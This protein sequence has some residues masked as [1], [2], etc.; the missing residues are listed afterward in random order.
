GVKDA[1]ENGSLFWEAVQRY[2]KVFPPEYSNIIRAGETSSQLPET[3]LDL[4]E[5]VEWIDQIMA[6]VRQA[7]LY[8]AV[9]TVVVGAFVLLLFT[10]VI[11]KFSLLFESIN[12]E[13]PLITRVLFAI[14]DGV[15]STWWLWT[16]VLMFLSVGIK[17]G[18][19]YFDKFDRLMDQLK[20]KVPIFGEMN[21]MLAISRFSHNLSILQ[22]SGIPIL[23]SFKYCEDLVGNRIVGE[24]IGRSRLNIEAGQTIS[25]AMRRE[26]VFPSMLLR[27][28]IMGESTGTLDKALE[29]VCD[30][31]NLVIP[32]RIKKIFGILEP[33]LIIFLVCIVGL[34]AVSIFLP[35]LTLMDHV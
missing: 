17:L 3:F 9:I 5:Y 7:S 30:Y 33:S 23:K 22:R 35:L 16:G 34:V 15:K 21:L 26:S 12:L 1:I 4:K 14:S 2:P 19:R 31:Y 18:R 28:V 29:A 13:L 25:E 27:M 6:D 24:A 11:P 10:F 20:L 8:P 32:R